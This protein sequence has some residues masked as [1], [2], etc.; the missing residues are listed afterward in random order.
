MQLFREFIDR[1]QREAKRHLKLVEQLLKKNGM[2]TKSHLDDDNPYIFVKIAK[3]KL[4]FDGIRIYEVGNM[5][6][7]RIQREEK[8]EPYGKAYMLN[9]EEMFNDFMGENM[10]EEAAGKKVIENVAQEVKKFFEKSAEAEKELQ[11]RQPE[12]NGLILKTGG[13]DYSGM[14]LNKG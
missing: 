10:E 9:I 5:M 1:R 8:T 3:P 2:E 7:Y 6:A 12:N 13:T 4:S 11:S 14:V